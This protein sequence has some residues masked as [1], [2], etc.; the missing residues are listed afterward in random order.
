MMWVD[1]KHQD[2]KKIIIC[3]HTLKNKEII[4]SNNL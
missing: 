3:K 1:T 2:H 4:S